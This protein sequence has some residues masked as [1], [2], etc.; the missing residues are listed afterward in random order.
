MMI[1]LVKLKLKAIPTLIFIPVAIVILSALQLLFMP[2]IKLHVVMISLQI[3]YTVVAAVWSLFLFYDLFSVDKFSYLSKIYFP[4]L[5]KLLVSFFFLL[6]FFLMLNL[7]LIS[8]IHEGF[9]IWPSFFLIA[10]Q[11]LI[12]GISSLILFAL[13]GNVTLPLSLAFLYLSAELATFGQNKYLYHLFILG[14]NYSYAL[15]DLLNVI[16]LNILI[17]IIQ[18]MIFR[19]LMK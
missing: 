17:G 13:V 8:Q 3:F 5:G 18:Y 16:V 15:N 7:F 19:L 1:S 9:S 11:M 2:Y 10:S 6:L 14:F 12:S 4:R